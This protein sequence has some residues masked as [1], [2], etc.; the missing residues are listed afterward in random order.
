MM[1]TKSKKMFE[2]GQAL[3]PGGVSSPVRKFSEVDTHPL[4]IE[5]GDG[6]YLIDIDGNRYLDVMC[7]LGPALFGHGQPKIAHAIAEQAKKG[8]VYA[9]GTPLEYDLAKRIKAHTPAIEKLRFVCSGTEAVMSAVRL[10]KAYSKRAAIIKFDG[11]Y[12]GHADIMQ[13]HLSKGDFGNADSN[14]GIDKTVVQNTIVLQYNDL[15]SVARA[16]AEHPGEIGAIVLEPIATNMGLV[17]PA[18]NFLQGLRQMCDANKAVLIFDEVVVGYRT[19]LGSVSNWCGVT[20]DLI[21][22][23]KIIGGGTPIGMYGG[24]AEIMDHL[25]K[26]GGVFQGGTFAGNALS[27]AAGLAVMDMVE[28]KNFYSDLDELGHVFETELRAG[29]KQSKLPYDVD[30]IGSLFTML[31]GPKVTQLG[32]KSDVQ[33]QDFVMFRKLHARLAQRGFMLPP[34]I[35]EPGFISPV[36]TKAELI[37]LAWTITMLL[38]QMKEAKEEHEASRQKTDSNVLSF[39]Q[40]ETAQI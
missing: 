29:F 31:L 4:Y 34:S 9:A 23:G 33:M 22:Y 11:C 25:D 27:M 15:D 37:D 26:S 30:R 18:P 2:E 38:T 21:T 3:L 36:H 20:P 24:R 14:N 7:G 16:F 13:G 35:E 39:Q 8:T 40:L 1:H 12:H 19:Q 5:R 17:R 32:S 10:A 6:G 28:E